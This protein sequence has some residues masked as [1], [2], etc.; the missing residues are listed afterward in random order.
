MVTRQ[1]P[2]LIPDFDHSEKDG[3]RGIDVLGKVILLAEPGEQ[4]LPA[5]GTGAINGLKFIGMDVMSVA[6][7][8]H[9]RGLQPLQ[10]VKRG[11]DIT[12]PR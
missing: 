12:I 9:H 8:L 5:M 10:P 11:R 1:H 2:A 3:R 4:S 7:V 6:D